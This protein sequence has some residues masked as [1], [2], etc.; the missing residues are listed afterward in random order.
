MIP[1]IV[2]IRTNP[3]RFLPAPGRDGGDRP[4]LDGFHPPRQPH[5]QPDQKMCSDAALRSGDTAQKALRIFFGFRHQTPFHADCFPS[6]LRWGHT[7]CCFNAVNGIR[8]RTTRGSIVISDTPTQRFNAVN[9]IR[10]RTTLLM[11]SSGPMV[12]SFNAVNGIRRRTTI[13]FSP[14]MAI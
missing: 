14:I 10:R 12:P 5:R 4:G 11:T 2:V 13:K 6:C 1:P 8:R 7:G 9:G 3:S